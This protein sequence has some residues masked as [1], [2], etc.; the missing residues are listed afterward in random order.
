MKS[1][2]IREDEARITAHAD[3][4][5]AGPPYSATAPVL[6]RERISSIDTL[7]GV[8]ILGILWLNI[9]YFAY[10]PFDANFPTTMVH[11]VF[12]GP[13]R[14]IDTGIWFVSW[15]FGE[16]KMRGMLSLLFGAGVLLLTDRAEFRGAGIRTADIY[17][18]R[19]LWLVVLGAVHGFFVWSGDILVLYGLIGLLFLFPLRRLKPRNLL[20]LAMVLLTLNVFVQ[21]EIHYHVFETWKIYR[22]ATAAYTQQRSHQPLSETQQ[23]AISSWENRL[24]HRPTEKQLYQEIANQQEG[25]IETRLKE[26]PNLYQSYTLLFLPQT[27]EVGGLMILGMYLYRVRFLSA[28]WS[29]RA[30]ARLAAVCL[31]IA[32]PLTAWAARYAIQG[33][34]QPQAVALLQ[35][36]YGIWVVAGSVGTAS[37]LMLVSQLRPLRP[38][39]RVLGDVGQMALT[40]YLLMSLVMQTLF[41]WSPLHWFGYLEYYKVYAL[42]LAMWTANIV[43]S[44]IWLRRFQ[45]G[46]VEWLWRSLTYGKRQPMQLPTTVSL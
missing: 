19:N 16:G 28:R 39:A 44:T 30:Y 35:G 29:K 11:P 22:A 32:W 8:A 42:V 40:N 2:S 10:P 26:A 7:R 25:Y 33:N 41:V 37:L 43:L 46:P 12:S 13:H 6:R 36:T 24:K 15:I 3:E 31:G 38:I 45:F 4:E 21:G 20:A 18:R 9:M 27:T 17:L 14:N 5:L 1:V 23:A 34:F